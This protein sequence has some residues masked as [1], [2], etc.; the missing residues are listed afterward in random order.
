MRKKAISLEAQN[1]SRVL[2][3][4]LVNLFFFPE[5]MH[6]AAHLSYLGSFFWRS[7]RVSCTAVHGC[8]MEKPLFGYL[9][10]SYVR[11]QMYFSFAAE[12]TM[13]IGTSAVRWLVERKYSRWQGCVLG[14]LPL[15]L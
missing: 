2:I 4:A 1:A 6:C 8:P 15:N 12:T 14:D 7:T 11:I 10:A 3:I 9:Y 13:R 5:K